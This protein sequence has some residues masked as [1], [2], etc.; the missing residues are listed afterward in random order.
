MKKTRTKAKVCSTGCESCDAMQSGN[1]NAARI[2]EIGVTM[3]VLLAAWQIA[4]QF[5]LFS[6]AA[7]TEEYVGL[8][9]VFLIGLTASTSSCLAMVGGL[10]LSVSASWSAAHPKATSWA[11]FQPQAHFNIGRVAGYFLF[12]GLTGLL[13]NVLILSIQTTGIVKVVLAL[14]MIA[15]GLQILG[16][17]PKKYCRIPLPSFLVKHIRHMSTSESTLAPF[18][19]GALT[20]FVPCGFTQSMQLLALASGSFMGGAAIMAV[21][22]LGTLPALLG[23]SAASSFSRGTA[24]KIFLTFAGSLSILLGL[25]NLESGLLLSG[26]NVGIPGLASAAEKTSDPNVTF[27]NN[28]QQI[29]SVQVNN[30]GYSADSFSVKAGVPTWIYAV[31]PEPLQGCITSLVVPNFELSKPL[32]KGENWIGPI[33]PSKDFAFMCSMGM[34][35]ANVQVRS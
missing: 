12:G 7:N 29:I 15:L 22:A 35:R 18:G 19:L 20:Y 32:V 23:I 3:V 4:T 30:S 8:G 21:F 14:V 9:T 13:G 27:D 33:T 16:L 26:I 31:V 17:L 5:E 2:A 28:G 10:L 24:G 25:S 11:R 6:F 1:M 34:F